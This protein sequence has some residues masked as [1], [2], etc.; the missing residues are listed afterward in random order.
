MAA[1][2][3]IKLKRKAGA[4]SNGE[5]AAG[6]LGLDV[7]GNKLYASSNGSTVFLLDTVGLTEVEGDTTP[8]LGGNLDAANY[9]ITNLGSPSGGTDAVSKNYV[10][11]RLQGFDW[12][13]AVDGVQEDASLDPGATPDTGARYILRDSGSLHANFGSIAGVGD[14]DIVEFDGEDWIVAYDVSVK[15]EGASVYDRTSNKNYTYNGTAWVD[16]GGSSDHGGLTGLGD[17]DH[18]QYTLILSGSGAPSSNPP[19]AGVLYVDTSALNFYISV[20]SSDPT[21]WKIVVQPT[22]TLNNAAMT[23]DGGTI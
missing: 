23:I 4:F 18:T 19:R 10:D 5:L 17:D 9:R 12:Q 11:A 22:S 8:K 14:N 1:G 13:A 7:S 21:D 2:V 6:E 20:G 15:G 16:V 3:V